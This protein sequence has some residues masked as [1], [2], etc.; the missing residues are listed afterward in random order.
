MR[1]LA[2]GDLLLEFFANRKGRVEAAEKLL[3]MVQSQ[4]IEMYVTDQCLD[5]LRFYLSKGDAQF[6][7]DTIS[8]I[9]AML[10]GY[11]LPISQNLIQK[12]LTYPLPDF[13]SAV[14]MVCAT[15][16]NLDA[17]ITQN[18]H[19]FAEATLPVWSVDELL[20]QQYTESRAE[21]SQLHLKRVRQCLERSTLVRRLTKRYPFYAQQSASDCGAACL[22]MIGRYWGKQFSISLLRDLANTNR[23][24]ASIKDLVA[25]AESIGFSTRPVKASLA[26]LAQQS[27]PA[28]AHWEGKHYI[29]VYEINTK[30]VI[31]CDPAIGQLSLTH[32]EFQANWTGYALLLQ[33]TALLKETQNA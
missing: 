32:K 1:V 31:V 8:K 29:V 18:Q 9:E 19:N 6:G 24:G 14:E 2:D 27:L 12:A 26:A 11:I 10:E 20:K 22:M 15:A 4:Q 23:S 28:I 21:W 3:E 30:R 17:I 5:K 25:A 13:E 16:M 7:E 33:S